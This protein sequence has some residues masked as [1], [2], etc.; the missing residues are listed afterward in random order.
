MGN[1]G[2]ALDEKQ[3]DG[4]NALM[5]ACQFQ[6]SAVPALINAGCALDEQDDLGWTAV[7][8]AID[9]NPAALWFLLESGCD[10]NFEFNERNPLRLAIHH[11]R[12]YIPHLIECGCQ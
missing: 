8:Y 3:N 11:C 7:H 5:I 12:D 2:C 4:R 9:Y 10:L 1:A 6:P